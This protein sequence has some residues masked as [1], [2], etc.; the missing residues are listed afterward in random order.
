MKYLGDYLKRIRADL[1]FSM[2]DVAKNSNLTPSYIS[3]IENGSKFQ[4]ISAHNLIAF[5]KSYGIPIP[6]ILEKSGFLP[7][8]EDEFP[9]LSSYLRLKYSAPPQAVQDMEFAWEIV[10]RKYNIKT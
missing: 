5:S 6:T 2:Y 1:G 3:K 7:P 8:A 10:K 4:S 9:G